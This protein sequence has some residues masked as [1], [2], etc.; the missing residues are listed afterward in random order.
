MSKG[1]GK[2]IDYLTE[3]PPIPSQKYALISIVGPNMRQKCDVWGLKIRGVADSLENAKALTKRIMKLDKDYDIYTVDMGK[4]FPLAVEPYDVADVEYDNQQLNDLIK[5]YLENKE[6]ANEHWHHRKQEMMKEAIREGKEEGQRELADKKE[7]PIAVLQRIK[8]FEDQIK[9]ELEQLNSLQDDLRLSKEK[10]DTYTLEERELA[11][12]ELR[13]AIETNVEVKVS[14]D[15]SLT[16]EEIRNEIMQERAEEQ[17]EEQGEVTE[18]DNT[19]DNIEDTLFKLKTLEDEIV[20][21][22]STLSSINK[23]TSPSVFNTLNKQLT[24]LRGHHQSLKEH[25]NETNAVNSYINHNYIDSK[26]DTLFE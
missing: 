20:E 19:S 18:L 22:E 8:S 3:D 14:E 6:K 17:G 7:H 26:H 12:V 1:K 5:S 21:I 11:D 24:Q 25:L 9:E 13:K 10:Y 16:I 4:F 15:T 2:A 23:E